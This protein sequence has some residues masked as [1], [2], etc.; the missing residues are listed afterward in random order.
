[1]TTYNYKITLTDS[2]SIMLGEALKMM[3][4]RC[5]T[6]IAKGGVAPFYSWLHSAKEV[7]GRLNSDTESRIY[8][9]L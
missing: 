8:V 3:I 4:E 6:E 5:E 9:S 7:R 2:E 1:M